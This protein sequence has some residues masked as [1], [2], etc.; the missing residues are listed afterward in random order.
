MPWSLG[1]STPEKFWPEADIKA[2]RHQGHKAKAVDA[3]GLG[4]MRMLTRYVRVSRS[5]VECAATQQPAHEYSVRQT[6]EP[7]DGSRYTIYK[8]RQYIVEYMKDIDKFKECPQ[9]RRP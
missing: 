7:T 8:I 6:I 1:A 3:S 2:Q 4:G 9:S 5:S